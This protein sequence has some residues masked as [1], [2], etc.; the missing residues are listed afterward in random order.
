MDYLTMDENVCPVCG[1]VFYT[2]LGRDWGWR[3]KG[4]NYCSYHCMRH[5]EVRHRLSQ[6][7]ADRNYNGYIYDVGDEAKRV[8]ATLR[9]V[10][11]LKQA[12]RHLMQAAGEQEGNTQKAI[13]Q[14]GN[15]VSSMAQSMW[16]THRGAVE[17]LDAPKRR[18]TEAIFWRAEPLWQVA[19]G[20]HIDTDLLAVKLCLVYNE[21]ARRGR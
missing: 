1:K 10:R 12:E 17:D 3:Y 2:A 14:I 6:G 7:W 20:E 16:E 9:T 21:I 13:T 19:A 15:R 8:A 4:N 5:V 18:L 11:H